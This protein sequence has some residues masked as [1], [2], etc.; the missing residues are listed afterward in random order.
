M[1]QARVT[2]TVELEDSYD[3]AALKWELENGYVN[4]LNEYAGSVDNVSVTPTPEEG[5]DGS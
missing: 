1:T 2:F 5:T 3:S 4:A